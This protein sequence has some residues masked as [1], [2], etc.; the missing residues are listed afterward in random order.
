[1]FEIEKKFH[2]STEQQKRLLDGALFISEKQVNDSYFDDKNF[3]L[4]TKDW[5]LRNRNGDYELKVALAGHD[6][7]VIN[8]YNEITDE[9]GIR[10]KLNLPK[11][12]SLHDD[13]VTSGFLPFVNCTTTRRKYKKDI[14]TIDLDE[15]EYDSD[16]DYNIAEIEITFEKEEDKQS[17]I[18][19]IL[20]FAKKHNLTDEP[21]RGKIVEY[22]LEKRPK[23]YEALVD[24]GVVKE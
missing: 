22:L 7:R 2:L 17:A 14:F 20:N 15:V 3:S 11:T 9:E 18:D 1:M 10:A 4:T 12:S 19:N 23:H 6:M 21:V 8:Q 24:A 16:F 13:I 5:W